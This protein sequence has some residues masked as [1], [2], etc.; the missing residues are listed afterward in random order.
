MPVDE[1]SVHLIGIFVSFSWDDLWKELVHTQ[2]DSIFEY[3][4]DAW[5][6]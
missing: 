4:L 5:Q 3:L 1:E 6:P 2:I